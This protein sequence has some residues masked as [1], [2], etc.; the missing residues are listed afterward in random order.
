ML[1][2]YATIIQ[3]KEEK[4]WAEQL[5]AQVDKS[6]VKQAALCS[7]DRRCRDAVV[8][9][10]SDKKICLQERQKK[11]ATV[12]MAMVTRVERTNAAL[13]IP[14]IHYW[15]LRLDQITPVDM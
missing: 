12:G 13:L 2:D 9:A 4:R 8:N 15:Q 3:R 11:E 10:S 1:C 7:W 6:T 14:S 5:L